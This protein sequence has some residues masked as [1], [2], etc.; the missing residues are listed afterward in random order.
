MLK[1]LKPV[2]LVVAIA[3]V[4]ASPASAGIMLLTFT[5][6]ITSS[7]IPG[8]LSGT[9]YSG[10]VLYD[11]ADPVLNG[12]PPETTFSF[13]PMDQLS[14]VVGSYTFQSSGAMFANQLAV[15]YENTVDGPSRDVFLA[16]HTNGSGIT[17]NLPGFAPVFLG[18]QIAGP[19]GLLPDGGLPTSVNFSDVV[20]GGYSGA[21][22][23]M[24]I[25]DLSGRDVRGDFSSF[26]LQTV[27]EPASTALVGSVILGL[28]ISGIRSRSRLWIP[29]R[30]EISRISGSGHG[31][32]I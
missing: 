26:Q 28:M 32:T 23:I 12:A 24:V 22:T 16:D 2:I 8:I 17:S 11:T 5:G 15:D 1:R 7:E 20:P 6:T 3:A 14:V 19:P 31:G 10:Q 9:P 21:S 25:A 18:F 29:G 13:G 30:T 27:P 4:V